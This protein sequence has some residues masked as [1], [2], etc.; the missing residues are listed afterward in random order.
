VIP[1]ARS[2]LV[3]PLLFKLR[4]WNTVRDAL[5]LA[6]NAIKPSVLAK[7]V[8]G[9]V[10]DFLDQESAWEKSFRH[11]AGHGIGLQGQEAPRIIPGSEDRF[12]VGDVF[13]LEPGISLQ[14]GDMLL[15]AW[16]IAFDVIFIMSI[17][18]DIPELAGG[19]CLAAHAAITAPASPI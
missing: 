11:H 16:I 7:D 15:I 9:V 12:E 8:F 1:A 14:P 2:R 3:K 18:S 4:A 10:K 17:L 13:T 19:E 5:S 6:E